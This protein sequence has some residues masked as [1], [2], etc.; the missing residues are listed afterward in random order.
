L[1]FLRHVLLFL[2][3]L[4]LAV[5]VGGFVAQLAAAHTG[6]F[7]PATAMLHGT[8][9]Q[10]V[11]GVALVGVDQ[12]ALDE[13]VDNAKIAVKLAVALVVLI[14][15]IVGRRRPL[16]TPAFLAAGALAVGNIGIAVFWT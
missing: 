15:I 10:L 12:G 4:G 16:T 3:F 6:P 8:I 7:R 5:L 14:L 13:E 1:E 2:H 11:T 9:T